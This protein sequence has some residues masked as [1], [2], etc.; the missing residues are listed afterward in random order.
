M[1]VRDAA[2]VSR[3]ALQAAKVVLSP[4]EA[5]R[6]LNPPADSAFPLEYAFH[7]LGDV[8]S[9]RVLDLGCGSGE[10]IIPL[11][12]RGALVTGIDISEDLIL[13]ASRRIKLEGVQA[14]VRIGSAYSTG[15]PDAWVDVVFCM[16]LI[17]HLDIPLAMAEMRRVL[18]PDGFIIYERACQV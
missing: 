3:S 5:S 11:A 16:G 6:Y 1:S 8:R 4:V 14:D 12:R 15:L 18:K 13:L 2:E 9:K 7:L 10:E 17:H